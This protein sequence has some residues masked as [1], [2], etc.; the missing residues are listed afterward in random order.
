MPRGN[1]ALLSLSHSLS[2]S[3]SLSNTYTHLHSSGSNSLCLLHSRRYLLF[4]SLTQLLSF[5][6]HTLSHT[7]TLSLTHSLSQ[8]YYPNTEQES[9]KENG[10]KDS[11]ANRRCKLG[12]T[13]NQ[14][15][16]EIQ[17]LVRLAKAEKVVCFEK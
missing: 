5:L 9:K 3:L 2:L 4:S 6:S 14:S 17:K 12:L 11:K 16:R 10:E 1:S 8:I 7:L 13:N 15:I